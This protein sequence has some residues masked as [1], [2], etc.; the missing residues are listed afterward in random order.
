MFKPRCGS[1]HKI[2]E[3]LFVLIPLTAQLLLPLF[4]SGLM[5]I[6]GSIESPAV[7]YNES[8][9]AGGI[10]DEDGGEKTVPLGKIGSTLS[11][12][13]GYNFSISVEEKTFFA[14][15]ISKSLSP[16]PASS[17]AMY[18]INKAVLKLVHGS[19]A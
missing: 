1:L 8:A 3:P 17:Q 12:N 4:M 16:L 19:G 7:K 15:V 2:G 5:L 18:F 9:P 10:T 14:L 11:W 6:I 13:T